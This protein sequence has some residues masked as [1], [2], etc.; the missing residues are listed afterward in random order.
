MKGGAFNNSHLEFYLFTTFLRSCFRKGNPTAFYYVDYRNM[1]IV[2]TRNDLQK[3]IANSKIVS[4]TFLLVCFLHLKD[5]TCEQ[6][7]IF[8]ISLRK[9]FSFLR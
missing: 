1:N 3:S 4:A 7:T 2:D 5:S 8:F 6:G 9:L